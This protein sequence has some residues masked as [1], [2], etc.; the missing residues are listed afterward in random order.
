MRFSLEAVRFNVANL[1]AA[2]CYP[3]AFT[4][5][6]GGRRAYQS[7]GASRRPVCRIVVMDG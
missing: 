4:R 7:E 1:I 5:V 2:A 3:V 6:D